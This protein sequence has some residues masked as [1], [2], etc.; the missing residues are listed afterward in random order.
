MCEKENE[1]VSKHNKDADENQVYAKIVDYIKTQSMK[2][3]L[4][5]TYM[6]NG[7]N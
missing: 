1:G 3:P 6:L 7:N 4:S 5:V 2:K